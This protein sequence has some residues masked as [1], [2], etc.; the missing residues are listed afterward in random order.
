MN[1]MLSV[2]MSTVKKEIRQ[3]VPLLFVLAYFYVFDF[4]S[5]SVVSYM[6]GIMLV[7]SMFTHVVRRLLFRRLNIED[8]Y[9]K[10][11]EA[12][13]PAA[14]IFTGVCFIYGMMFLAVAGMFK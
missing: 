10:A 7:I 5:F 14:L 11:L 2:F 12:P 4:G 6:L 8:F 3:S 9:S 1:S 13:L